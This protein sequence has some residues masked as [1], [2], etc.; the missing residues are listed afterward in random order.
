MTASSPVP[1]PGCGAAASGNFC[2]ACGAP[3]GAQQCAACNAALSPGARFCHKCG[4]AAPG[5]LR[6]P[7]VSGVAGRSPA[8]LPDYHGMRA[9]PARDRTAWVVAGSMIVLTI[10]AVAYFATR[11]PEPTVPSMANAGNAVPGTVDVGNSETPAAR[12]PDIS[13]MTPREQYTRLVA[14]IARA[15]AV[16]DSATI[17]NFTPM[18]LGAYSN[19]PP[20][21]RDIDARF[22][23]A[24]LQLR[25][26][27]VDN[28]RALSDTIMHESPDNLLGYYVRAEVAARGGDARTAQA[29]R[30]AFGSHYDAEMKQDRPEY[31][32]NR[33]LLEQYRQA[34]GGR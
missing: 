17:I 4:A 14:R 16:G 29:A 9:L 1:C 22:H 6:T 8:T 5:I 33:P 23:A 3:L 15:E 11:R 24:L 34:A 31:Q 18:A 7:G 20:G 30:A 10:A 27:L 26:G 2:A 19:L 21:D 28:A 13:N 12:A 25:A 32:A